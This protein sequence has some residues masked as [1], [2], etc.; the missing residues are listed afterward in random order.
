MQRLQTRESPA[1]SISTGK[2]EIRLIS[3]FFVSKASEKTMTLPCHKSI[4][5]LSLAFRIGVNGSRVELSILMYYHQLV[6][7]PLIMTLKDAF[8]RQMSHK[9]RT[10]ICEQCRRAQGFKFSQILLS[11]RHTKTKDW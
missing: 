2:Y 10:A 6:S 3:S 9:Y 11:P 5:D 8:Q 7:A 1:V 4:V